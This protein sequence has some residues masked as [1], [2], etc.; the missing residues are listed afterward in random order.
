MTGG[1]TVKL[2]VLRNGDTKII[3]AKIGK[4]QEQKLEASGDVHPAL[5]GATLTPGTGK[6]GERGLVVQSL[7][8]DSPA[9]YSGLQEKDLI[10]EV[11]R[12]PVKTLDDLA[13]AAKAGEGALLL[14]IRRGS[15]TL[16]L[17]LH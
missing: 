3:T 13:Q 5:A 6:D 11:N 4:K 1:E 7:D 8:P 15:A 14:K 17:F 16:L 12:Q 10:V 2:K 9:A